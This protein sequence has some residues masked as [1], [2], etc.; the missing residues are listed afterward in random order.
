VEVQITQKEASE[1]LKSKI[2]TW[3]GAP[4]LLWGLFMIGC[5]VYDAITGK[6][7]DCHFAIA[8]EIIPT[9]ILGYALFTA[10]DSLITGM[11]GLVLPKKK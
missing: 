7:P 4:I 8:T 11:I 10:K 1:R 6:C 5:K 9:I 3:I 2:T